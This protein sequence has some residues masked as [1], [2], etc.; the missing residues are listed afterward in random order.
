MRREQHRVRVVFV[1][2]RD[3]DKDV[4]SLEVSSNPRAGTI[5]DSGIEVIDDFNIRAD[6]FDSR[7]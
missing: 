3:F 4:G 7:Q 2:T 1:G 5:Y 6:G